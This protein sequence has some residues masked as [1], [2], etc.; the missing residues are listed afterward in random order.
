M[1]SRYA[2]EVYLFD[3]LS[4]E[5][6]RTLRAEAASLAMVLGFEVKPTGVGGAGRGASWRLSD[7]SRASF[8]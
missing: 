1:A 6:L 8:S 2:G 4:E 7:A 5:A 3:E